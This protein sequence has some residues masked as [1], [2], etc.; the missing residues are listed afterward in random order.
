MA[1]YRRL[2]NAVPGG[3]VPWTLAEGR[4]TLLLELGLS[5]YFPLGLMASAPL[6]FWLLDSQN[7]HPVSP[8]V[9][10]AAATQGMSQQ[11]G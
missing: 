7:S 2:N 8:G 6:V 4:E 1:P 3:D 11:P 10:A 5:S 9:P